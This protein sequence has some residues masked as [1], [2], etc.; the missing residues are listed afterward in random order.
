MSYN[1]E[2]LNPIIYNKKGKIVPQEKIQDTAL[3]MTQKLAKLNFRDTT[4]LSNATQD[5]KIRI[6]ALSMYYQIGRFDPSN[7][8]IKNYRNKDII[9]LVGQYTEQ[10][11]LK[12]N[13][14]I[15]IY[16]YIN[17]IEQRT[18]LKKQKSK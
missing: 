14:L 18:D 10:K 7:T 4:F 9:K 15:H 17:Q 5:E 3:K 6:M 2:I 13:A 1:K 12:T 8:F 11:L 16:T